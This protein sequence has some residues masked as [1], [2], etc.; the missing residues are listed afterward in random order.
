MESEALDLKSPLGELPNNWCKAL[1]K[2]IT[3]KIGSGATP[4]G[5]QNVYLAHRRNFALI[6]SQNVFDRFFDA[7]GLAFIS[8]EHAAQLQAVF[9]QPGDLL[10]NITGD[11]ITFARSTQVPLDILPACV[12]QHVAIIR[13][14]PRKCCSGYLLSYLTHPVIKNYI[15]SFNAGGSRRAI[16]KDN[17]ESFVIPLPPLAEQQAIARI[18]G[19]FDDKIELNRQMNKTLEAIAQAIF[20]S[21][22]IDFDPVRAKMEGREPYGM[23]AEMATLFPDGFEEIEIEDIPRGWQKKPLDD[24][25]NFLN[26]LALQNFPPHGNEYLPVI[27]IAELRRGIT[28]TTGKASTEIEEKYIIDDGDIIFS[29]SGSLEVC[30]WCG[31]KGALNQHLFK[32][33]SAKYPKWF[34]YHWT[35]FH[36][37]NFQAIAAGKATTMGHI[38]RHHLREATVLVPP[39]D[40][41]YSMNKILAPILEQIINNETQIHTLS[42]LRDALIPKLTS[43]QIRIKEAEKMAEVQL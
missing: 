42:A 29:W 28:E 18:L 9:V 8:D 7:E 17:I 10:L 27:K 30:I 1:L 19:S 11:G 43:G 32:V 6:R 20:K 4:K 5:G 36:L 3:T 15:E 34:F 35:K 23:D 26:G 2:D 21:W 40:V 33:T 13:P 39:E 37:P 31:G 16:T 38:Q 12:N 25:A 14:D 24:I 41:L 22:F